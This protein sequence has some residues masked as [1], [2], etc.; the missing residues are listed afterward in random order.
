MAIPVGEQM[1]PLPPHPLRRS[2]VLCAS[3]LSV[4]LAAGCTSAPG[5]PNGPSTPESSTRKQRKHT[6]ETSAHAEERLGKQVEEALGTEEIGDSDP[7]FVEAGLERVSDGFHTVPVLTR[8]RSYR[9]SVVCAGKGKSILSMALQ[10]PVHRTMAC[11]GVPLRRRITVPAAKV[12]I[13]TEGMP[14]ATGM[15][16]WR[17]DKV[18]R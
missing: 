1:T 4:A 18:D 14:G 13:D 7:L 5:E 3:L 17:I 9:L 11:D 15:V 8:G 12:K 16:A 2:L 10:K 6:S